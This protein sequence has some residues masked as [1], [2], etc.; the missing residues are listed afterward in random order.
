MRSAVV[1]AFVLL[2]LVSNAGTV[3]Q[4]DD[5]TAYLNGFLGG[6]I[7][8]CLRFGPWGFGVVT[9]DSGGRVGSVPAAVKHCYAAF[10]CA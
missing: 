6:S 2:L 1:V 9:C 5:E 7:D 3:A 8:K 10:P 4:P